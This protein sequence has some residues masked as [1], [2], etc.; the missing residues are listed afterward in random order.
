MSEIIERLARLEEGQRRQDEKLDSI[1]SRL[2]KV[3]KVAEYGK[4]A[5]WA[6][7]KLGAATAA[8]MIAAATIWEKLRTTI[9]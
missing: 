9:Q 5:A 3:E 1:D 2:L 7:L 4:G 6:L 8:L